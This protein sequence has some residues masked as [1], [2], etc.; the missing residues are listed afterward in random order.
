MKEIKRQKRATRLALEQKL[1][2]KLLEHDPVLSCIAG[3]AA[4]TIA[5]LRRGK[6]G[7]T[8]HERVTGRKWSKSSIPFGEKLSIW[9]AKERV[10]R[11]KRDWE[12][13]A[14]EAR[15]IGHHANTG[16]GLGISAD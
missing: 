1:G 13:V 6:D 16:A 4:D 8:S 15:Y 9:V 7:K 10:G 2:R 14:V 12:A 11:R 3:L 5:F